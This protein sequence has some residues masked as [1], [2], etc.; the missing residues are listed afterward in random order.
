MKARWQTEPGRILCRWSGTGECTRYN[1]PWM[2][3][4]S[5]RIDGHVSPAVPDFT[6]H[7]P[8]GSGEWYVPWRLRWSVPTGLAG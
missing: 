6:M 3:D 7:S 8:L 1:P 5:G 2:Q 4:A